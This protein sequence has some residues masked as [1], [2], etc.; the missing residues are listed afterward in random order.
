L[1]AQCGVAAVVIV[2]VQP[3]WQRLAPFGFAAVCLGVG[4]FVEQGA[5]EAFDLAVGLG[6][7]GTGAFV[8]DARVGEGVAPQM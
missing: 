2:G 4:P 3:S 8:G 1:A 7:V 6:P 5:V